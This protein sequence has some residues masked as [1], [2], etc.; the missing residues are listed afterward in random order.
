MEYKQ[1]PGPENL[2][3]WLTAT[4]RR[5]NDN[6]APGS[7]SGLWHKGRRPSVHGIHDWLILPLCTL[8]EAH[9]SRGLAAHWAAVCVP[10]EGGE[11]ILHTLAFCRWRALC[12]LSPQRL[13][14]DSAMMKDAN[15][16]LEPYNMGKSFAPQLATP[17]PFR[18]YLMQDV[19]TWDWC[20]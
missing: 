3:Q 9:G 18:L 8:A 15:R 1:G 14:E 11:K 20:R 16:A 17:Y 5:H 7:G 4:H 19:R 12:P 10:N 6:M 13:A 2:W